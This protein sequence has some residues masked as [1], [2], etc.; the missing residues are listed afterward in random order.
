M[1]LQ[2]K[3][4]PQYLGDT[5][6]N[7]LSSQSH[8]TQK[9]IHVDLKSIIQNTE[10]INRTDNTLK[11]NGDDVVLSNRQLC[12]RVGKIVVDKIFISFV[13]I[14]VLAIICLIIVMFFGNMK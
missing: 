11:E 8:A 5:T 4:L 14:L 6:T 2:Q 10:A 9:E 12:A 7:Q 1:T 3:I 13:C